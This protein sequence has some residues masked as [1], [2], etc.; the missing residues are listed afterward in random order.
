MIGRRPVVVALAGVALVAAAFAIGRLSAPSCPA[1][2]LLDVDH[3]R[4]VI[5]QTASATAGGETSSTAVSEQRTAATTRSRKKKVTAPDGTI[6]E[7]ESRTESAETATRSAL[8]TAEKA[9]RAEMLQR[10]SESES[11][12]VKQLA[13]ARADWGVMAFGSQNWFGGA[14]SRRIVGPFELGAVVVKAP[15]HTYAGAAL[16]FR[17]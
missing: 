6:T 17:W 12:H 8:A 3:S 5:A 15:E 2:V 7:I 16:G 14:V 10:L 1:P 9:W 11:E 4:D 13:A